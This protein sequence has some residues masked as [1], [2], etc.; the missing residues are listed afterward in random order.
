MSNRSFFAVHPASAWRA[1]AAFAIC[2]VL[3]W[4]DGAGAAANSARAQPATP[5]A[6]GAVPAVAR[7]SPY[8]LAAQR[9]AQADRAVP[10]PV[11]PL[12]MQRT[13]RLSGHA[14]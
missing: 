8:V 3:A 1:L 6:S 13:H 10:A 2:A 5:A 12:T 11:S 14:R 7:V 9:H 4:A